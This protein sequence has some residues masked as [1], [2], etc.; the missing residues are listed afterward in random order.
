MLNVVY[1]GCPKL[2]AESD[3]AV[4]R[5]TECRS[6]ILNAFLENLQYSTRFILSHK[7]FTIFIGLP[8]MYST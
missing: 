6:A 4:C 5:Y 1:A 7:Y 8:F 2:F 3:Y